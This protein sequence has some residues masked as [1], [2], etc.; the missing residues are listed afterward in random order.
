MKK[1]KLITLATLTYMRAQ[2]LSALLEQKGIKSFMTNI[3][4]IKEAAG[5]VN[6]I[7]QK[8]DFEEAKKVFE[9]FKNAYGKGKEKAAKYMKSIRRIL[10]PFDF[11][12]HSENAAIYALRI[13][14]R[15]KADI[16]LL[17]VFFDPSQTAYAPLESF[18]YSVEFDAI[19]KDVEQ[20]VKQNLEEF[21]DKL[22]KVQKEENLKGVIIKYD[23]VRGTAFD[24][25]LNYCD[26]YKP[27]LL[28]MGTRG[29]EIEGIRSFGSVTAKI[30]EKAA[31]PVLAVPKGYDAKMLSTPKKVLYA[32]DFRQADYWALSKLASFVKPFGS[33][34]YCVHVDEEITE[35]HEELMHQVR[36]FVNENLQIYNLECGL[37]E[38]VD[39]RLGLEDFIQERNMDLLAMTTHTRSLF[40][41]LFKP[42]FTKKFLFVTDIPLLVFRADPK[43]G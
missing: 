30:I 37:L 9:D 42:S 24:E 27:G 16:M 4:R 19:N 15:L 22:K 29:K 3:N 17:N 20:S 18:A 1:D 36:K 11:T 35:E 12:E 41:R 40:D 32:T 43:V 23:F 6:V 26:E 38:T 39:V 8:D 31:I 34:I 14:S 13:A 33:K 25:I 2:L 10:V 7:I 21:A 28:V 5:G